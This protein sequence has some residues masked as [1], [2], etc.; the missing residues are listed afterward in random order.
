MHEISVTAEARSRATAWAPPPELGFGKVLAPVL[1]TAR[2]AG[3]RWTGA[4]TEPLR[5]LSLS[6]AAKG[7]HY[8]LQI[9]EGLKAYWVSTPAPVL[10]R[11]ELNWQ[12]LNAATAR[13]GM[14]AVPDWLFLGGLRSLTDVLAPVIPRRTGQALYLRPLCVATESALGATPASEFEFCILASPSDAVASA[15]LRVLIER[16][17]S[18]AAPGGLGDLKVAGNYAAAMAASGAAAQAG[19]DQVLWLDA[20][21]HRF[22]EELSI[23]NFFAVVD[24]ELHTPG[25]GP[26]ILPGVTRDSLLALA[27]DAG[28]VV[29]EHPLEIDAL[30][31]HIHAGECTEAFACGTAAIVAPIRALVEADGR[32]HTLPEASGPVATGLRTALLDLQEGRAPDR[33]G[34]LDRPLQ[35]RQL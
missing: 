30:C 7:L 25:L 31:A 11:P 22:I 16:T 10:F 3:G 35:E 17:R 6:P 27:R 14:P 9:F 8:G 20:C 32:E 29:R 5:P 12:R 1:L 28:L 34:W 23:M 19:C 13:L 33:R 15:P 2:F 26:T 4:A 18:R 21:S 24:G